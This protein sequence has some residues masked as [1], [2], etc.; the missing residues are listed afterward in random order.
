M[1]HVDIHTEAESWL[2]N[3]DIIGEAVAKAIDAIGVP[4][5]LHRDVEEPQ[6]EGSIAHDTAQE[7]AITAVADC[8]HDDIA[9][10]IESYLNEYAE[11]FIADAV[12][13]AVQDEY[14]RWHDDVIDESEDLK[15]EDRD[16]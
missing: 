2:R 4:E 10:I 1:Y 15:K 7:E 11:G 8:I 16:D 12:Q 5:N 9:A 13:D 3:N 14:E 6:F